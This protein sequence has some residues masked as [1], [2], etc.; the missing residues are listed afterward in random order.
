MIAE[1]AEYGLNLDGDMVE[2]TSKQITQARST[3]GAVGSNS[4]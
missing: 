4:G 1:F 2:A 3:L